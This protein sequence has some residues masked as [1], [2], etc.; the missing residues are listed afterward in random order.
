MK[1]KARWA[2]PSER[3]S[4][5]RNLRCG[6]SQSIILTA[7][8]TV[9]AEP[10]SDSEDG[11]GVPIITQLEVLAALPKRMSLLQFFRPSL[12][13]SDGRRW[14]LRNCRNRTVCDAQ[15]PLRSSHLTRAQVRCARCTSAQ[16]RTRSSKALGGPLAR[17]R[18]RA[19]PR[20]QHLRSS[21]AA[22]RPV[23]HGLA[24][25]DTRLVHDHVY[26]PAMRVVEVGA[27]TWVAEL[28]SQ[29]Q[30]PSASFP[31]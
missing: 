1:S 18:C 23:R 19:R 9:R 7:I 10:S 2:V 16:G 25:A 13:R 4:A 30:I 5:C 12:Q 27:G 20:L 6:L 24:A 3:I 15:R 14:R 22:A 31:A 26:Q 17:S 29:I 21:A 11:S 28:G 8:A